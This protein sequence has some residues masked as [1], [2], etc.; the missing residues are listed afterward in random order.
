M[1]GE[2][3]SAPHVSVVVPVR[4][5]QEN[6]GPLLDRLAAVPAIA[7]RSE[8]LIVD[9]HSVDGTPGEV[10]RAARVS[11]LPVRLLSWKGAPGK[12]YA[13]AHGF[14][15]AVA[16]T[17]V[18]LDGDLQNPPEDIPLVLGALEQA[19]MA[20]GY[21]VGR[22]DGLLTRLVSRPA[23]TYRDLVTGLPLRDAG[24]AL[25]AF[26]AEHAPLLVDATPLLYGCAHYFYA[27]LFRLAGLRVTEVPVSH[28][29]RGA[30]RSKFSSVRGRVRIG[31]RA[32]ATVRRWRREGLPDCLR[33]GR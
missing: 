33:D 19:D 1:T 12:D 5:E 2:N 13:L 14:A 8:I 21:R 18:T 29:A 17:I 26:R 20:C 23:N 22:A 31:I 7:G 32:C 9:D 3:H 28:A 27:G 4:D 30:G 16:A 15:N 10:S 25:K 6:I 24:C 11:P